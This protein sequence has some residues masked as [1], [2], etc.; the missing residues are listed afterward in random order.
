MQGAGECLFIKLP[1]RSENL[2]VVRHAVGNVARQHGM[3]DAGIAD[4][5]IVVTEACSNVVVHAYGYG[6]RP[7]GPL[8]VEAACEAAEFGVV[9]RDYGS[10]FRAPALV[11]QESLRLG[12]ALISTLSS[13]FDVSERQGGG[14]EVSVRLPFLASG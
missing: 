2:A 12:L 4:L 13:S 8:E 10:G 5:Q 9:V 7:E 14:T 11:E 3:T 1:A 6:D